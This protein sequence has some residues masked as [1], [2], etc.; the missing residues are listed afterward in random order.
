MTFGWVF[1]S[2]FAAFGQALGWALRKKSLHNNGLGNTLGFVTSLVGGGLI[3]LAWGVFNS[4]DVPEISERFIIVTF[5][6]ISINLLS[7]WTGH[8]AMERA[9]LSLLSPY[10]ALSALILIPLEF[11]V[12][13]LLPNALQI[14]GAA[15]I[16]LGAI[17]VTAKG[18]PNRS[19]YRALGY[20][21]I[22]ILCYSILPITLRICVL[23]AGNALF[24]VFVVLL[25]MCIGFLLLIFIEKEQKKIKE[26]FATGSGRPVLKFMIFIGAVI[27]FLGY[28]P[29]AL[30]LQDASASEVIALKRTMPFFAIILGIIM[31]KEKV[32]LRHAM[33]TALL[34][35]GCMLVVWFQ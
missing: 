25:G 21:G 4:W 17:V 34:V 23:E 18:L 29:T 33:G 19:S 8:R 1:L 27:A 32:T 35:G 16:V 15:V 2:L 3:A 13:D 11:M 24:A 31:F 30:A 7:I 6:G 14:I 10:M 28:A 22:T 12:S 20:Y 5:I 9:D 26:L